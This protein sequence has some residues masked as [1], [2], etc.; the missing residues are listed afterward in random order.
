MVSGIVTGNLSFFMPYGRMNMK[1][2][3][4]ILLAITLAGGA[5]SLCGCNQDEK[6][7]KN[8]SSAEASDISRPAPP[9]K[10]EE[11]PPEVKV[12]DTKPKLTDSQISEINKK[13]SAYQNVPKFTCK[14]EEI[15]ARDITKNKIVTLITE[16]SDN[17]YYSLLTE[18]FRSA[19]KSAGFK[20]VKVTET[21]G[22]PSTINDG[23]QQALADKSDVIFLAGD[24]NKDK[25]S[26]NIEIAQSNGIEVFSA[27]SKGIGQSD[28]IVDY[29]VP[30]N[31]QLIGELMADWG[32]VQTKGK[33][34][35][36]AVHCTDSPFSS[37]VF[38]GFKA[39]FE[40]YVS[41]ADGYCTMLNASTSDIGNGLSDKIR[42]AVN[43]DHNIN[44]VFIFD[45]SAISDAVLASEQAKSKVKIVATGGTMEAFDIAEKGSIEMLIAQSYEWTA[46]AMVDYGLR[47]MGGKTLP[48]EQDVPVRI[49]TKSSIEK[50]VSEYKKSF[51]AFYEICFGED[52][53]YNYRSMWN[54]L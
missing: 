38:D 9:S 51:D 40:K 3:I 11:A 1:R 32:I 52:Y 26:S 30:I 46:Y 6:K 42:E 28:H 39:E 4:S 27:G 2:I 53:I 24:I 15:D 41:T 23:L 34:N 45:D 13:L 48:E 25:V 12:D 50:A 35:A 5:A 19:A 17:T 29:T 22:Q 18:I 49:V 31:Y 43:N 44:Y 47:V 33:I 20:D 54:L 8:E 36:L 14:S 7:S 10:K 16:N 21:D 37:S